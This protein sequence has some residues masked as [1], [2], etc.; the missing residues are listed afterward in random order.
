MTA[1]KRLLV[2]V[3]GVA[4][5]LPIANAQR[6]AAAMTNDDVIGLASAGMGDDIIVAKIHAA[7]STAF[8]TSVTGLKALKA[9]G[10][11]TAVIRVMIDPKAS[12][13]SVVPAAAA[14][15]DPD[16]PLSPH[17]GFFIQI[18]GPDG[19]MH[20]QR[21]LLTTT[22]GVKGPSF[23]SALGSAYSLGLHKMKTKMV[24]PGTKAEIQTTNASPTFWIYPADGMSIENT[25]LVKLEVKKENREATGATIGG[26][27]GVSVG[28][29]QGAG[30]GL[31]SE[32]VKD[33]VYKVTVVKPLVSGS[34]AFIEGTGGSYR[35]F[36]VLTAP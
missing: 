11:S 32:R 15:N 31:T 35:D 19:K 12:T 4:I 6:A 1:L 33:G 21:L 17:S 28:G 16:D 22:S 10:V 18:A 9:G 23:G 24:I 34:Y 2:F 8:D 13:S 30:Q 20:L 5:A 26:F 14:V 27:S 7:S 25:E 3:L 36:D 29:A